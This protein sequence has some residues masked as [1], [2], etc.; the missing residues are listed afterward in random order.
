MMPAAPLA[1]D[2]AAQEPALVRQL[3]VEELRMLG[4]LADGLPVD[5]VAR[6]LDLSERTV[7][8]RSRAVCDRLGA[9]ATI[10]VVAWAAREGLI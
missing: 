7:R 9:R 10:Q 3:S 2:G 6:R 5:V 1:A 4:L 8:R